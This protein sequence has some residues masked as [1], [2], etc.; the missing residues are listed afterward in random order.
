MGICLYNMRDY[1]SAMEYFNRVCELRPGLTN[2][3]EL[4]LSMICCLKT[5]SEDVAMQMMP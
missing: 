4:I 5:E 1:T 3:N 2:D